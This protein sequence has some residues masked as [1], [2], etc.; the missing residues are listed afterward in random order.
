MLREAIVVAPLH[1][2]VVGVG[3]NHSNLH[4]TLQW[5]QVVLVLQ[6]HHT[7]AGHLQGQCAVFVA[8][9]DAVRNLVP[10]I[11]NVLIHFTQAEA[12]CEQAKHMLVDVTL[13]D[14]SAT[15][16]IRQGCKRLSAFQ[17]CTT[18]NG[19]GSS[20]G[21]IGV[22]FMTAFYEEIINSPAVAHDD[23]FI[24]PVVT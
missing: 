17:V 2:T 14:E 10:F 13:L 15:H 3:T 8:A 22:R 4:I 18:Q 1:G 24:A 6:E 5:Q 12:C 23:A 7:L 20:R 19:R 21:T 16:G 11:R 9:D